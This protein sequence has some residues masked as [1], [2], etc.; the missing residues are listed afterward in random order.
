M[1]L[2]AAAARSLRPAAARRAHASAMQGATR[3]A[4][5]ARSTGSRNASRCRA[6]QRPPAGCWGF[7]YGPTAV[8]ASARFGFQRRPDRS[9][10]GSA[11]EFRGAGRSLHCKVLFRGWVFVWSRRTRGSSRSPVSEAMPAGRVPRNGAGLGMA[12]MRRWR[13]IW[14]SAR[15]SKT[16]LQRM[17]HKPRFDQRLALQNVSNEF[18]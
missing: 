8:R 15:A 17:R 18:H 7:A 12:W 2:K 13:L 5:P 16:P 14:T 4:I 10:P 3:I 1:E 6:R 11:G 9:M